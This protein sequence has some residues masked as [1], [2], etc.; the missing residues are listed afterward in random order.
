MRLE[1]VD[2]SNQVDFIAAAV[3]ECLNP[4]YVVVE[5]DTLKS[6]AASVPNEPS[7]TFIKVENGIQTAGN[8]SSSANNSRRTVHRFVRKI[9][10]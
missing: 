10:Q 2:P 1:M 9:P 5:A 4:H 8:H 6:A 3:V 7:N